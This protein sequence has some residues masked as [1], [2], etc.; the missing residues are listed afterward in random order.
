MKKKKSE[1][2]TDLSSFHKALHNSK[3]YGQSQG[4]NPPFLE[5][6]FISWFEKRTINLNW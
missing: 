2:K 3:Y 5:K 6:I 1:G 4:K